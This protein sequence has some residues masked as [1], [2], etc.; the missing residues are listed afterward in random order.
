MGVRLQG[1]RG[2]RVKGRCVSQE[3]EGVLAGS[4]ESAGICFWADLCP[5]R[6]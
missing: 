1:W 3:L 6:F 2:G 5:L 4:D